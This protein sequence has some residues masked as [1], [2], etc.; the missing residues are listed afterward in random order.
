[1]GGI[2]KLVVRLG[3]RLGAGLIVSPNAPGA[4]S[5]LLSEFHEGG[6]AQINLSEDLNSTDETAIDVEVPRRQASAGPITAIAIAPDSPIA[7]CNLHVHGMLP[8]R[9]GI[10]AP[11]IGTLDEVRT[12]RI[13]PARSIP[14]LC[15]VDP[16]VGPMLATAH[17]IGVRVWEC[18][19]VETYL[20]GL[21]AGIPLLPLKL[22]LYRGSSARLVESQQ[23]R[24]GYHSELLFNKAAGVTPT[25]CTIV[26][27][28]TRIRVRAM[29]QTNA[30]GGQPASLTIYGIDSAKSGPWHS[31]VNDGRVDMPTFQELLAVTAIPDDTHTGLT[32]DY[33]GPPYF[34]ISAVVS[35]TD[36]AQ[37]SVSI[38]AWD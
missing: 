21:Q 5:G 23:R 8:F 36:G 7:E 1:M 20:P 9:I 24:S 26:D 2:E 13:S 25:L 29:R 37:G 27:G 32:F 30:E 33:E 16:T 34:A 14:A 17:R 18:P 3:A 31:I 6:A 28:R 11:F 12:I 35:G 15:T 4:W 10:G 38:S 22:H 19:Q